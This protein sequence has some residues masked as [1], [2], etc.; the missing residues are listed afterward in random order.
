[1]FVA[2]RM[3]PNPVTVPPDTSII[4]AAHIMKQKHFRRL[5]VVENGKL[6]GFFSDRDLMRIAPS[7]ATSLSRFEIRELLTKI[8]VTEIMHKNVPTVRDDAT[9][10]EA[11]L[12]MY[13]NKVDGLPV[14]SQLG[15]VV[16]IITETDIFKALIDIMGLPKGKTR[17]TLEV[18]NKIGA[19]KE[20]AEVFSNGGLNIDS[21]ITCKQPNGKYEFVIRG[22]FP[23]QV[24]D[25][26]KKQLEA[27]GYKIIHAVRI[28]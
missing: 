13:Q 25:G 27:K 5:P 10:E 22:N 4:D 3:T 16:G 9:I 18:E 26:I 14:L 28:E 20:I 21:L 15:A 19:V 12:I 24:E 2:N 1:M 23:E 11:S 8:K 17:L 6:V 7:P